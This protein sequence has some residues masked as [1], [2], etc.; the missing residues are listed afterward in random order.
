VPERRV[1]KTASLGY[2]RRPRIKP[3]TSK[4]RR[5]GTQGPG[6]PTSGQSRQPPDRPQAGILLYN[7]EG[8]ENG[9]LIFGGRRDKQ[10]KVVDSGGSLSF[11]KYDANQMVH[12]AGIE[13]SEDKF[14]GLIVSDSHSG[15]DT[16]RIWL[17][18]NPRRHRLDRPHGRRR[19]KTPRPTG[20]TRRHPRT[21]LPRRQR[22]SNRAISEIIL[23]QESNNR[24]SR[25]ET[26][27]IPQTAKSSSPL[28]L[29]VA[30]L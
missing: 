3:F 9:G 8:S 4:S 5:F 16:R 30:V 20:K 28:R 11:D 6:G 22:I 26:S 27:S 12:L 17:S 7:D 23:N 14:A 18:R 10:G 21:N 19:Q 29:S 13:D 2:F 24:I 15:T 25:E 1:L